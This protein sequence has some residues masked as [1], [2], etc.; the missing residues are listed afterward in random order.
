MTD[1]RRYVE[2]PATITSPT[3]SPGALA[4]G[5]RPNMVCGMKCRVV[6]EA[7]V[8][9]FKCPAGHEF[10]AGSEDVIEGYDR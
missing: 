9:T 3:P 1:R 8:M 7:P 2:C 6:R 10:F 4:L 5:L